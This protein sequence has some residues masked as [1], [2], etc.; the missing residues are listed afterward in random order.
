[1]ME[2]DGAKKISG[3]KRHIAVD[4]QGLPHGIS[5]RLVKQI[6]MEQ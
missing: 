5:Q 6:E 3:I 2:Y 1:M 4:S